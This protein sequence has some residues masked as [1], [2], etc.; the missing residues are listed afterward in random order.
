MRTRSGGGG[1]EAPSLLSAVVDQ[2]TPFDIAILDYNMPD[3]DGLK[4]A[5]M[6]KQTPSLSGTRLIL[7]SSIGTRGDGRKARETGISGYLTKPVRQSVLFDCVATV[8][9][10]RDLG[11]QENMGTRYSVS[12]GREKIEG[13]ILLVAENPG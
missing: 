12:G 8:A 1:K 7:L 6:I 5:W 13:R 10:A 11:A 3:L 9:G 2:G 4:L